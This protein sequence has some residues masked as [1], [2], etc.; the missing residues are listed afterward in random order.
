MRERSEGG[1]QRGGNHDAYDR[2][3]A[4]MQPPRQRR[5][6]ESLSKVTV[7]DLQRNYRPGEIEGNPRA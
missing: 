4:D 6:L 3:Y 5:A 2:L 1:D 7:R